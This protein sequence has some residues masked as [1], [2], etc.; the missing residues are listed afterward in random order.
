MH[1]LEVVED[2]WAAQKSIHN[3]VFNGQE[4]EVDQDIDAYLRLNFE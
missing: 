3:D 2:S 1:E 4:V